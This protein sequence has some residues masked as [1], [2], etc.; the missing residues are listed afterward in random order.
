MTRI[1]RLTLSGFKSFANKTELVLGPKFNCVL[2]PN[3]SGKSNV[4]DAL[5]FV[6]GKSSSKSM[7]A[8]KT[9]NLIYNGGKKK[10]PAK[11]ANVTIHFDN[12]DG[13]FSLDADEIVISRTVKEKGNSVYK[14][15]GKTV[16]RH[17]ILELLSS[18]NLN[19]DGYNI[20]LQGD[21][22]GLIEMSAVERRKIIEEIAGISVYEEKKQKA[23]RELTKVEDMIKEA[24]IILAEREVY[25]KE[26]K[27][28]RNQA[29]KF[30]ELDDKIKQNKATLIDINLKTKQTKAEGFSATIDKTK[31]DI[32]KVES[33]IK[34]LKNQITN[35]KDEVNK[36]NKEIEEKS[37]KDQM[38]IQ[39]QVEQLRVDYATN[40]TKI[41]S[42]ETEITR[43]TERKAQLNRSLEE[44]KSK[45]SGL[46][47]SKDHITK[48]ISDNESMIV[49]I[50]KKIEK[51]KVKHKLDDGSIIEDEIE[52]LDK[53]ADEMQQ[54]VQG[55]RERQQN[56]LREKDKVDY[57]IHSTDEKIAKVMEVQKEHQTEIKKLQ[58][59]K[60]EFKK[61]TVD[62]NIKL[63]EDSSI[64]AQLS[65]ARN[66]LLKIKEN[67]AKVQGQKAGM[68]DK[69]SGGMAIAKILELK[70]RLKG[71]IGT[72]TEL[73]RV[74]K[75]YALA[76]EVAAGAKLKSIVV[77]NDKTAA[78]CI[79][80]LKKNR[81]GIATFLPLNKVRGVRPDVEADKLENKTG[82]H[83]KAI[84]LIKFDHKYKNIYSYVFG[85]TVIVENI[86]VARQIGIG[87]ARMVSLEG[88]IA[89]KS[90]AMQ[91][92]F[93]Q[94]SKGLGFMEKEL[95]SEIEGLEKQEMESVGVISNLEGKKR[96]AEELI[97]T[98]RETKMNLEGEIIRIEKSLHL[99]TGDL[100]ASK[101]IKQEMS[102]KSKEL[103]KD[104]DSIISEI[105]RSNRDL[106]QL[107]IK[108]Q[109]LRSKIMQLKNPTIIAE[110]NTFEQ[111]KTELREDNLKYTSELKSIDI[112]IETIFG[113]ELNNTTKIIKQ[114]DKEEQ[115]FGDQIKSL[116]EEVKKQEVDLKEKEKLQ[117]EF[118]AEFKDMF[119]KRD[120]LNSKVNDLDKKVYQDEDKY[121]ALD[122]K[123]NIASLELAKINTEISQLE[124][125]FK[126]YEGVK[127]FKDKTVESI[128]REVWQ[129][130]K[131]VNDIGAVNMRALE[132]Y[133]AVVK[134][135]NAIVEKKDTLAGEKEKI[136]VMMNEIETK[137]KELF[138]QTFEVI[139]ENF[140][141]IFTQLS[142]K[143]E[144]FLELEEP[145]N[146]FDGGMIIKVRLTGKKFMDIRSL[147]GGEKT[148]TALAFL[149]AVQEHNP[150]PFYVLDEV[151]AALDK[152]NSESLARLVKDYGDRAQYLIISHNDGIISEADTLYGVSMNQHGI[153]KV[154]SLKI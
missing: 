79:S 101:N 48:K 148:M 74:D 86:G 134:E 60:K 39:K 54:K 10:N 50:K 76:M 109:E 69:F 103:D 82:V 58:E 26:L 24:E 147:S 14:I 136:L 132:I 135:F 129:F 149:F 61:T 33:D 46:T 104:I 97:Q 84:N 8:E 130:E 41:S 64:V 40:K 27:K 77:D 116:K 45:S 126:Q 9:A 23:L 71:I 81:L 67:L 143:G 124:E 80:Y 6:L 53:S 51:F 19:P 11:S 117:K 87:T 98:L 120:I 66:R 32:D 100:D 137:K 72:V 150:A 37:D 21:I 153:S 59:L 78:E 121:R 3:G 22:T 35:H 44:L 152:R 122:N 108:K 28:E 12:T 115:E 110:L 55:L 17:Q 106:A 140:K 118:Y 114:H 65:N 144:A 62:L 49:S 38:K 85:N 93:R 73:G 91:G 89:E 68:A 16:T 99:E 119:K 15:N 139:T 20:I 95:V 127:L 128:K 90:G 29:L 96:Q 83:G 102:T 25:L 43:I 154:L 5:C 92:G 88:D 30:K 34:D 151:D 146:I 113:P 111:K 125:D 18:A 1:N 70:N 131:M 52:K 107:K 112:Q 141:R 133:E 2:G 123:K 138:M 56:L 42:L 75:K 57:D 63:N 105:S 36:I 145:D 13:N 142:T 31:K 47:K 7:R 94:K 4:M